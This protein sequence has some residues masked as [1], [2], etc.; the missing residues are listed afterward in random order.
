MSSTPPEAGV[1]CIMLVDDNEADNV[2]HEIMLR[3]AGFGGHLVVHESARQALDYLMQ[4]TAL[5]PNLILLDINMPGMNGFEFAREAEPL[6]RRVP[7]TT[8]VMLTSSSLP[9]DRDR[10][11]TMPEIAGYV[12]KPLTVASARALLDG[13]FVR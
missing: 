4:A 8:V 6:L 5:L 2:Y 9:E 10:A 11:H 12:T 1:H 3:R 7:T 13:D